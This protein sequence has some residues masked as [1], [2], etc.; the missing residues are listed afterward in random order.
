MKAQYLTITLNA[1][2]LYDMEFVSVNKNFDRT[3]KKEYKDVY[4]DMLQTLFTEATGLLIK[5]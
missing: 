1:K 2:D 3:I 5:F 4:F